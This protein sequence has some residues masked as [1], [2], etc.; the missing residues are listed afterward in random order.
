MSPGFSSRAVVSAVTSSTLSQHHEVAGRTCVPSPAT[1]KQHGESPPASPSPETHRTSTPLGDPRAPSP[2]I[3][4]WVGGRGRRW[5]QVLPENHALWGGGGGL[6]GV[7]SPPGF[8]SHGSG[9]GEVTANRRLAAASITAQGIQGFHRTRPKTQTTASP[10]SPASPWGC[11][12]LTG[13]R[14]KGYPPQVSLLARRTLQSSPRRKGI[15]MIHQ[16]IQGSHR[17]LAASP[18][19][20]E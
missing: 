7:P 11:G 1:T 18:C 8:A 2:T 5:S 6:L 13:M 10:C 20:Q 17:S 9:S 4:A 12:D 3:T 19:S 16:G 14:R 15:R